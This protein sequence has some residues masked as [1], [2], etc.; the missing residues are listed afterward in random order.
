MRGLGG[1]VVGLANYVDDKD[2][3][4]FK[5]PNYTTIG[6]AAFQEDNK[7]MMKTVAETY[8]KAVAASLFCSV[9]GAAEGVALTQSR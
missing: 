8:D 3:F 1:S 4:T 7:A 5:R 2:S 9:Y 6:I